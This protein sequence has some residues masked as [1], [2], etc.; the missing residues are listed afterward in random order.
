[1]HER[2][3]GEHGSCESRH[4]RGPLSRIVGQYHAPAFRARAVMSLCEVRL[5]FSS[6]P[7]HSARGPNRLPDSVR[8]HRVAVLSCPAGGAAQTP[9]AVQRRRD[10]LTRVRHHEYGPIRA[11]AP[12][13][14]R[15]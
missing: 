11:V 13:A 15:D 2:D 9:F 4:V 6:S 12:W 10:K 14:R 7:G 1:L 5:E 3:G 8:C